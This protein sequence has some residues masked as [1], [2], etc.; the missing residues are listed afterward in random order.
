[1]N[2][3]DIEKE[4]KATIVDK[5]N[6]DEKEVTLEA[7]LSNDLGADSLDRVELL[8]DL[9]K[10]FNLDSTEQGSDGIQTVGDVINHIE[11]LMQ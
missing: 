5:L 7:H 8:M 2:K 9:E 1:M 3:A 4:V 10:K 11:K 6:V